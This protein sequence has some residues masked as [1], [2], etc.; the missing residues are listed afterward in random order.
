[1]IRMLATSMIISLAPLAASANGWSLASGGTEFRLLQDRSTFLETVTGR[2][3][4]RF[5]ITIRVAPDG[6]IA[7]RAF[8]RKVTGRWQW[9]D[10]YFCRELAWGSRELAPNCQAVMVSGDVVRFA[11]DRGQGDHAD[12]RLD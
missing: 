8:G 10:G 4:T 11:S 5:G 2:A 9:R 12:L 1:M 7:G 3:L 6:R